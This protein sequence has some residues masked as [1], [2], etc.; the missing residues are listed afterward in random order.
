MPRPVNDLTGATFN[1]GMIR[2][3]SRAENGN[4]RSSRWLCQCRCGKTFVAFSHNLRAG[5]HKSCGCL[6]KGDAFAESSSA[7]LP[8]LKK[9]DDPY[10]AL[11][12]AIIAVAADDYRFALKHDDEGLIQSLETFFHSEWYQMLT[13]VDPDR[14]LGML[15]REHAGNLATAY[16]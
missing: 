3:I 10:Q 16:I 5:R 4:S 2:V 8:R 9:G 1:D 7:S 13:D 12:N 14:L 15:R 11:A 6:S